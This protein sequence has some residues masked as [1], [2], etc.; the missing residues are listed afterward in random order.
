MNLAYSQQVDWWA[1]HCYVSSL[2]DRVGSWPMAG[3]VEWR[4]LPAEDPRKI[5]ALFDAARHHALR[6]DT[7]QHA[8]IQAGEAISATENWSALAR[9]TH[10]RAQFESAHPWAKR[11]AA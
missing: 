3:T 8:Q 11:V 4:D 5:A 10:N 7:A 1:V 6:V 2:L 9:A